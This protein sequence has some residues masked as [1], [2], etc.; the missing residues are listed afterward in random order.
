MRLD[1]FAAKADIVGRR[2]RISWEVIPENLETLAD[3]P[4]VTLRRKLRDFAYPAPATPDPFTVYDST[5]FPPAPIPNSLSVTDL[6]PWEATE[7]TDRVVYES[8]SVAMNLG[9]RMIEIFRRTTG[10]VYDLSGVAVKQN[11]EILDVGAQPGALQ[12][13]TVYYYQLFGFNLPSTGDEAEPYRATASVTDSYATNRVLYRS[14]PEVYRSQ[15]VVGTPV[16][17]ELVA[18]PEAQTAN[19]GQLQRFVDIFGVALD[20]MRGSASALRNLHDLDN[21]EPHFLAQI[22]QWIGWDLTVDVDLPLWRNEIKNA[23]RFY[24]LVGTLPGMRAMVSQFTGWFTQAAEMAQN[25]AL[26]NRP[27]QRNP[28]AITADAAG[29]WK[30]VDDAAE[31]LGFGAGNQTAAGAIGVAATLTGTTSEPFALRP[32]MQLTLA[33]DGLLP[34]TARFGASDF[35]DITKA[36]AAEVSAALS[37]VLRELTAHASAGRVSISSA[38]VGPSSALHVR[39]SSTSLVSLEGAPGGRLSATTDSLGRVR[40]FY[41]MWEA[42]TTPE[43]GAPSSGSAPPPIGRGG[44]AIRRVHY[45]TFVDGFWRD[46]QPIIPKGGSPQADPAAVTLADDRILAAWISDPQTGTSRLRYAIGTSATPDPAQLLGQRTAPFALVNNAVLTLTGDFAGTDQYQVRAVD[47]AQVNRA[48]IA[49]VV[50]AMNAQLTHVRAFPQANGALRLES[51]TTGAPAHVEIDLS[52]STTARALGF[53]QRNSVGTPGSFSEVIDW[54]SERTAVSVRAGNHAESVAVDDPAG[55]VRLAWATHLA[56]RWRI[57]TTVWRER[58]LLGTANGLFAR[59]ASGLWSAIGG[60]P[61]ADVRAVVM[62]GDGT[63]WIAT[64]AGVSLLL[65]DGTIASPSPPVAFADVRDLS[66]ARDGTVWFATSVGVGMRAPNGI[67]T[68]FAAGLPSIDVHAILAADDGSAWA[69]TAGGAARIDTA[70][71]VEEVVF[72]APADVRDVAIGDDENVYF[73]T[74]AGLAVRA[75]SGLVTLASGLPSNDVRGVVVGADGAVWVATAA[76]AALGQ[77]GGWTTFSAAGG[78]PSDD[79]RTVAVDDEGTAWVGTALG[80]TLIDGSGALTLVEFKGGGP[81]P[82]VRAVE[83]GWGQPRELASG[84]SGNREPSLMIDATDRAWLVWSQRQGDSNQDESWLLRFRVYDPTTGTWSAE[85]GLTA[86]PV[87]GRASDRTPSAVPEGANLRV[88]FSS[89]RN[90]GVGLWNL[91]VTSGGVPGA[92]AS[93]NDEP[94][95]DAWPAPMTLG[96]AT[97][98]LYRSDANVALT[99]VGATPTDG[100]LPFTVRLPDNGTVR[101]YAGTISVGLSDLQRMRMRRLFGDMLVYTP[102]RPAA[103]APLADDELYTRG[104]VALYVTRAGSGALLTEQEVNRLRELLDRFIPINLRVVVVVVPE[105]DLEL[106]YTRDADIQDSYHDEYPFADLLGAITDTTAAAMPGVV[107]MMSNLVD[108][109]SASP[110]DLTTLRRRSWFPPLQ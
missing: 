103:E 39:Q 96:G 1:A 23:P 69:A 54:S 73:A 18:V 13:G 16:P 68:T 102:N 93:I 100:D 46:S 49:E 79:A 5:T 75:P 33:V 109:V 31:L 19:K 89:D 72:P 26:A 101:R 57:V 28:F 91:P 32:G 70:G 35:A 84:G 6:P 59:G 82:A 56:G 62:D 85:A 61:S 47:F 3:A 51:L 17:A 104:T 97:W 74:S 34:E 4:P 106:V 107:V 53:D 42:P 108:N 76:G 105:A 9:G 2:V 92:L 25:L 99:Q 50:A 27:P 14:L 41:E 20:S 10:T 58:I 36:T 43:A 30:G 87:G 29:G 37:R 66:L 38:T 40:L 21:V 45:K 90:G 65:P 44:F 77:N 60:L 22:A 71:H 48:T 7:G 12:A 55:G 80:V 88:Y 24:R 86:L 98:I 11:V 78:L 110:S 15:D 63:T 81:D 64:G 83:V 94:S 52:L 67:T 8:I 95:N